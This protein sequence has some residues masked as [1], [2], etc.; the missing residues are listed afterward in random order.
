MRVCEARRSPSWPEAGCCHC[1]VLLPTSPY[2]R[3]IE[4]WK[5][6]TKQSEIRVNLQAWN[7]SQ[8]RESW[9]TSWPSSAGKTPTAK[10]VQNRPEFQSAFFEIFRLLSCL[11]R[12]QPGV[13]PA[14]KETNKSKK[15]TDF[16]KFSDEN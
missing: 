9:P 15:W 13:R 12:T 7:P 16:G 1:K 4:C 11:C 8:A 5:K 14:R 6:W 2:R 3:K 10:F